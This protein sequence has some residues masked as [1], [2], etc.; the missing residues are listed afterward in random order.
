MTEKERELIAKITEHELAVEEHAEQTVQRILQEEIDR[1]DR[2]HMHI[3]ETE[4]ADYKDIW[5]FM[6]D[7]GKT[8]R[9]ALDFLNFFA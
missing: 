3:L 2:E 1:L 7:E 6:L 9:E 8:P 5:Q 4:W